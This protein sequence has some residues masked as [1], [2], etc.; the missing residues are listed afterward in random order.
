MRKSKS[1]RRSS[2]NTVPSFDTTLLDPSDLRSEE[3]LQG[4]IRTLEGH[5]RFLDEDGRARLVDDLLD[6][7]NGFEF[8]MAGKTNH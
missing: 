7:Q 4:V 1:N 6:I 3:A 5:L 2:S 8:V